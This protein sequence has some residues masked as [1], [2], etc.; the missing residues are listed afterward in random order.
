MPERTPPVVAS[1]DIIAQFIP[2]TADELGSPKQ[3]PHA[4]AG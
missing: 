3:V 1:K 4:N 2:F